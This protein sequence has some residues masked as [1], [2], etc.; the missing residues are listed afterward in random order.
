MKEFIFF[1]L[2]VG[3]KSFFEFVG[4]KFV[5][6][7]WLENGVLLLEFCQVFKYYGVV[8]VFYFMNFI[9][10]GE[11]LKIIL[12]VGQLGFGKLILGSLMLGFNVLLMGEVW[13]KGWDINC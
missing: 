13:F 7:F 11:V 9:F 12:I 6:G 5:I 3:G 10:D 8:I 1:V 2:L 4:D